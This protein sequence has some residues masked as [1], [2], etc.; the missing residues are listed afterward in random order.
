[1]PG[2]NVQL[3]VELITPIAMEEPTH[4]ER[5]TRKWTTIIS[6]RKMNHAH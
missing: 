4:G 3:S 1:M 5:S 6:R 2:D